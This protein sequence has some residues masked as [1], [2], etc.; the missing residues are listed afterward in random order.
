[1]FK[2]NTLNIHREATGIGG[3]LAGSYFF[4]S[5]F[6]VIGSYEIIIKLLK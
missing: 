1:M 4:I 3:I 6:L 2:N 5:E